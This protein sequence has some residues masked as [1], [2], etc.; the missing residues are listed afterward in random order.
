[1]EILFSLALII[2]LSMYIF[3]QEIKEEPLVFEPHEKFTKRNKWFIIYLIRVLYIVLFS[4]SSLPFIESQIDFFSYLINIVSYSVLLYLFFTKNKYTFNLIY[5]YIPLEAYSMSFI[6]IG[7]D[8][9]L[10]ELI[11]Y[12]LLYVLIWVLPNYIYFIKRRN[13]FE[14]AKSNVSD[15]VINETIEDMKKDLVTAL[16]TGDYELAKV[17]KERIETASNLNDVPKNK[18]YKTTKTKKAKSNNS[19][20]LALIE[21]VCSAMST[22]L[23]VISGICSTLFYVYTIYILFVDYGFWQG[24]VGM[25]LPGISSI[26]L[27]I[28]HWID[29]GFYNNVTNVGA[30]IILLFVVSTVLMLIAE[31]IASKRDN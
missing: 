13:L 11:A 15:V 14:S 21:T 12:S 9:E 28:V 29:Y 26:Y 19:N 16:Q 3:K 31:L 17:I 2:L 24:F 18:K 23:F 27:C 6:S 7:D 10:S 1:M 5:F 22:F 4:F 25:C 30:I 8:Y 20:T